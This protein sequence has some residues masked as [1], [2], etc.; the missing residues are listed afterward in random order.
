MPDSKTLKDSSSQYNQI[1]ELHT[2]IKLLSVNLSIDY[3][4]IFW[5]V[6]RFYQRFVRFL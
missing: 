3:Q 6:Y 2:P 5:W 4:W 1:I